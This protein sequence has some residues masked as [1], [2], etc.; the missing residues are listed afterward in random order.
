MCFCAIVETAF[1]FSVL[2]RCFERVD[3]I[4]PENYTFSLFFVTF[5]IILFGRGYVL[6]SSIDD[7]CVENSFTTLVFFFCSVCIYSQVIR[8]SILWKENIFHFDSS[9]VIFENFYL[10][11]NLMLMSQWYLNCINGKTRFYGYRFWDNSDN[12]HDLIVLLFTKSICHR[13]V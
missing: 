8:K 11:D 9:H 10:S 12:F 3:D 7:D 4:L 13:F 5:R 2:V 6:C 1:R